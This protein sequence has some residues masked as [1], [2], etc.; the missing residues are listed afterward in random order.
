MHPEYAVGCEP[1]MNG[2]ARAPV[3]LSSASIGS[4]QS[5]QNHS[6]PLGHCLLSA[7]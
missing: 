4:G 1:A 2:I 3:Q 7:S 6:M 5:I